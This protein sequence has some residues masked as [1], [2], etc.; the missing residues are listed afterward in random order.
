M[1]VRSCRLTTQSQEG[2]RVIQIRSCGCRSSRGTCEASETRRKLVEN[3]RARL[4]NTVEMGRKPTEPP[5]LSATRVRIRSWLVRILGGREKKL[6]LVWA[7]GVGADLGL[8][9]NPCC[10]FTAPKQ[11]P[12]R[13]TVRVADVQRVSVV[14]VML[15]RVV[16]VTGN[17]KCQKVYVVIGNSPGLDRR[18]ADTV[19]ERQLASIWPG[20]QAVVRAWHCS[21]YGTV[22]YIYPCMYRGDAVRLRT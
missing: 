17:N 6:A 21:L 20:L 8:G 11:I 1:F 5:R 16:I 9:G 22:L 18:A 12:T 19:D 15:I 13:S 3:P 10:Y 7:A 4:P 14:A 2:N